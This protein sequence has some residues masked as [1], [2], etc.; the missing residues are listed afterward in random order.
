MSFLILSAFVLSSCL[1]ETHVEERAV[2]P[3]NTVNGEIT[4]PSPNS[5]FYFSPTHTTEALSKL[6]ETSPSLTI[7]VTQAV[8]GDEIDWDRPIVTTTIA[9]LFS[10]VVALLGLLGMIIKNKK[11]DE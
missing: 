5:K 8:E 7:T 4:T 3:T 2:D 1:V 6:A 11:V 9:G 10:V